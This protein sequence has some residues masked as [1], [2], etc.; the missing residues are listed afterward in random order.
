MSNIEKRRHLALYVPTL[1]TYSKTYS[2]S[3]E[4]LLSY[5]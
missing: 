2:H 3:E 5:S 1:V 4:T